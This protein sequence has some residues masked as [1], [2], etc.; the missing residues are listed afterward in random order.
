MLT[1]GLPMC[2]RSYTHK[3]VHMNATHTPHTVSTAQLPRKGG[4][5]RGRSGPAGSLSSLDSTKTGDPTRHHTSFLWLQNWPGGSADDG[6]ARKQSRCQN[7]NRGAAFPESVARLLILASCRERTLRR[8][9]AVTT[10]LGHCTRAHACTAA[11]FR[12]QDPPCPHAAGCT[13]LFIVCLH[14]DAHL[15]QVG[16]LHVGLQFA[17]NPSSEL[18]WWDQQH[19]GQAEE[20]RLPEV[21]QDSKEKEKPGMGLRHESI[22]LEHSHQPLP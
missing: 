21:R 18:T 2:A 20:E 5:A 17:G 19:P 15:L 1:G 4:Q 12:H 11:G 22:L 6:S 10:L 7:H 3:C 14:G 8:G 9:Y 16:G 13:Y